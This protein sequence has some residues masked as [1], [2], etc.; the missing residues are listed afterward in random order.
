MT[1]VQISCDTCG[2]DLVVEEHLRTSACPYCAST[3]VVERPPTADRPTPTF[4]VGF[5]LDHEAAVAIARRWLDSRGPF[6][7]PGLKRAVVESTRGVYLPAWLYG[8]RASADY[9]A[10][11]GENYTVTETYTTPGSKGKPPQT[12]TRTRTETEWRSLAGDYD[13]YL[14]DVLVSAS[15]GVSNAQLEAVEPFDLRTLRRYQA[16][17]L[18]GWIAEEP[19]LSR[20]ECLR[21]AHDEALESIERRLSAFMPGDRQRDLRAQV[22]L[23]DELLHL[24]LLPLWVFSVR[25]TPEKPPVRLLINGQTGRTAGRVPLSWPRIA[26]GILLLIALVM[27]AVLLFSGGVLL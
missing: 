16:A 6:S 11:I 2:A 22:Q 24:T 5:Q 18:A 7:H 8:A 26:L 10:Q 14:V 12:R 23:D 13:T 3:S 1:A 9:T 17:L 20:E 25:Y 4:V 19:T 15:R 27:A 21:K